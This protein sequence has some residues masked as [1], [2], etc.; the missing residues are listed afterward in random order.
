MTRRWRIPMEEEA[1]LAAEAPW[2]EEV[3]PAAQERRARPGLCRWRAA[4]MAVI[5]IAEVQ[6]AIIAVIRR[7]NLRLKGRFSER[8]G[9]SSCA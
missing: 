9:I 4:L 1:A 6:P 5:K 3:A 8:R 2:P 7:E